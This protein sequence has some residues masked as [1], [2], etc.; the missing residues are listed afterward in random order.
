MKVHV[1]KRLHRHYIYILFVIIPLAFFLKTGSLISKKSTMIDELQSRNEQLQ[2]EY[3]D[4]VTRMEES[5]TYQEKL[6]EELSGYMDLNQLLN[7]SIESWKNESES[8]SQA[9][10]GE[11]WIRAFYTS[12]TDEWQW[13]GSLKKINFEKKYVYLTDG[14]I[15]DEP[16]YAITICDKD[17]ILKELSDIGIDNI[18]IL[19]MDIISMLESDYYVEMDF[20]KTYYWNRTMYPDEADFLQDAKYYPIDMDTMLCFS[21]NNN[22][23]VYVLDRIMIPGVD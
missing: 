3:E 11:W 7:E 16:I 1:W 13:Y 5:I 10:H 20:S 4:I 18:E 19:N 22:V 9:F 2:G 21:R 12:D 6:N 15:T 23:K 14:H 8:E 17:K